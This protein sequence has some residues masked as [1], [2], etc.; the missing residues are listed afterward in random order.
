MSQQV[1]FFAH[2]EDMST[3]ASIVQKTLGDYLTI[4]AVRGPLNILIARAVPIPTTCERSKDQWLNDG[5]MI[6]VPPWAA[7]FLRP[8]PTGRVDGEFIIETHDSPVLEYGC[9]PFDLQAGVS[10]RGRFYWSF[11]GRLKAEQ[12]KTIERLF[13]ALR[14][15][16]ERFQESRFLRVF[17][18]A[19]QLAGA[20][21][22][23][24]GAQ[25][26]PSPYRGSSR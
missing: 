19:K 15:A 26:T 21:V 25:P 23:N 24:P 3:I 8:T 2:P 7:G 16:S 12:L 6:V 9:S 1:N 13:R 10:K 11:Q 22:L 17:P 14:A 4:K 20:F 5:T 18:K